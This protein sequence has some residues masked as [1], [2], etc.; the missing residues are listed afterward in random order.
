MKYLDEFRNADAA[1]HWAKAIERTVTQRWMIMEV[2]G[3]QTHAIVKY[4][5]DQIL[6]DKVTLVH[7]PGCPVCVTP[8][9][10]I[11]HAIALALRPQ[12]DLVFL[13]RYDA[14]SRNQ[15]GFVVRQSRR[16]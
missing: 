15:E 2:C 8:V 9:S 12:N 16:R 5:L 13:W 1:R 6:P 10:L 14:R 3:G 4:G 7:G 11:D